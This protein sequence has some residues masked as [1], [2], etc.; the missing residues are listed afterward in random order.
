MSSSNRNQALVQ[1]LQGW[2]LF[3]RAGRAGQG[4]GHT[5]CWKIINFL[6]PCPGKGREEKENDAL[7]HTERDK[8]QAELGKWDINPQC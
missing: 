3:I 6:Q 7:A 5:Q 4:P 2:F 8:T 1:H